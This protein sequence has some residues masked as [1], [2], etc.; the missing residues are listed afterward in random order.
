MM[1][2]VLFGLLFMVTVSALMLWS[3]Q[4]LDRS[5]EFDKNTVAH[6]SAEGGLQQALAFIK[7]GKIPS[8]GLAGRL[9]RG[10]YRVSIK[11]KA[12]GYEVSSRGYY[13]P[14]KTKSLRKLSEK[15]DAEGGAFKHL[16]RVHVQITGGRFK[17][18]SRI[19]I[20]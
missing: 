17:T 14:G 12:K 7:Q 2:S 3:R 15:L 4:N 16:I 20:P 19:S 18:L 5:I 11:P 6:Y 1:I 13:H 9:G 8:S 10:I